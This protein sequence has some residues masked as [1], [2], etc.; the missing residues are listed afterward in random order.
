MLKY[1]GG[2]RHFDKDE[3]AS[4]MYVLFINIRLHLML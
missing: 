3:T 4:L 1:F 2:N